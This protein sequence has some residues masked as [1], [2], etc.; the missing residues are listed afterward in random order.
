MNVKG[1]LPKTDFLR[2]LVE[3]LSI[4]DESHAEYRRLMHL[5]R[6]DATILADVTPSYDTLNAEHFAKIVEDFPG[7]KF[8]FIM[9][10][11]AARARSHMQ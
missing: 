11:P 3:M 2:G 5:D 9:R 7:A 1:N 8:L 10:D 4:R 6:G